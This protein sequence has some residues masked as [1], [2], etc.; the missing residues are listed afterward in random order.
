MVSE[1]YRAEWERWHRDRVDDFNAPHSWLSLSDQVWLKEGQPTVIDGIPGEWLLSDGDVVYLPDESGDGIEVNHERAFGPT[2]IPLGYNEYSVEGS[3]VPVFYHDIELEAVERTN[4]RGERIVS[5][6]VHDPRK[7]AEQQIDDIETYPLDDKWIVSAS[8]VP[9]SDGRTAYPTVEKGV[10]ESFDELGTVT[11]T[12]DGVEYPLHVWGY[13][14]PEGTSAYIHLRD[15][16]SGK[17]TYGAGRYVRKPLKDLIEDR[18][19]DL[20]R[21]VF[22]PCAVTSYVTCP[23]PPVG[24]TIP[25]EIAA[26]EKLP[27]IS[28][29]ERVHTYEQ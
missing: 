14:T 13:D 12:I 2:E 20:N 24:N 7:A 22:F 28:V 11:V 4:D 17:T 26:G 15:A 21:L 25:V 3:S 10:R 18:T 6:R 27:P 19:L 8:F 16:T 23:L 9:D 1:Q 5:I 29:T